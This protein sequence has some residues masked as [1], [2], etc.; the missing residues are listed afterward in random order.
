[1]INGFVDLTTA[2]WVHTVLASVGILVG[3][4]QL[5]RTRRDWWHRQLGYVYVAS[6]VVADLSILSV[7][8]FNGRF[9]AFHVGAIVNLLCLWMALHPMLASPRPLQWRLKHYMWVSWSYVGLLA[10]A[11][12]EFIIRTQPLGSDGA[13]ILATVFAST[14]VGVVGAVLIQR[15][16]PNPVPTIAGVK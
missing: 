9:N 4:E 2:G 10:A 6:M 1:M 5:I 15:F 11:L 14:V 7:Y 12:T 16:R 8:R 3:A 13:A